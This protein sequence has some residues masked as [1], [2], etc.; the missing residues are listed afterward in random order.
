[1]PGGLGRRASLQWQAGQSELNL[2]LLLQKLRM[3]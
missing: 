3:P 2:T 1:M